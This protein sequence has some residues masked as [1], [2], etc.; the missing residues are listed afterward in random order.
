MARITTVERG[1]AIDPLKHSQPL[2]AALV[3]LGLAGSLPI[4]HGSKGCASFAKALLTR[5]FNEPIPLQTT[6]ISEVTAVF[7]SGESMVA[8]LDAI[9]KKQRP[10]V[11]GLLTTGVTEVS[12]EDVG[13]QLRAY[14]AA[15]ADA[16]AEAGAE[17]DAAPLIVGVSTPDFTGGL[18]DG[19][20]AA[21][22]ALVRAVIPADEL[23]RGDPDELA[24]DVDD[25]AEGRTALLAASAL[26]V[27]GGTRRTA[28]TPRSADAARALPAPAAVRPSPPPP[29]APPNP[30]PQT[31]SPR[32]WPH[33]PPRTSHTP[34][35]T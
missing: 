25:R 18:S 29:T 16:D 9:R 2:G 20:S 12:G 8:T 34:E 26:A 21:L 1:A 33:P 15:W 31:P 23:D 13:G 27:A 17:A 32:P 30:P 10:E 4:M 22:E 14:L 5:H 19:W 3:F 6:G 7:G 28:P 35:S 24:E 11:I